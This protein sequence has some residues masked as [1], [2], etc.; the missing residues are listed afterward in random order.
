MTRSLIAKANNFSPD[1]RANRPS[2]ALLHISGNPTYQA[3]S[4]V[5][6]SL[7]VFGCCARHSFVASV[8]KWLERRCRE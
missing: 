2:E 4:D 7:V 3:Q 1:K 6:N 8:S 5:S